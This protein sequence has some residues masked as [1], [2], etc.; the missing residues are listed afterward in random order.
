LDSLKGRDHLEGQDVDSSIILKR[1]LRKQ[2]GRVGTA[3]IWQGVRI[4]GGFL[5]VSHKS[6]ELY[7]LSDYKLLKISVPWSY[8]V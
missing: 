5:Y 8:M 3:F 6:R 1:I 4:G 7:L 2:N